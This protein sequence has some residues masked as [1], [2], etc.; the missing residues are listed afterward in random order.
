MEFIDSSLRIG[1]GKENKIYVAG[2][3]IVF[4]YKNKDNLLNKKLIVKGKNEYRIEN[5]SLDNGASDVIYLA[6]EDKFLIFS[7]KK[8]IKIM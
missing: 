2:D 7:N 4:C 5:E 1:Y 3:S 8:E 6:K